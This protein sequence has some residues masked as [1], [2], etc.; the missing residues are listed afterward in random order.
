MEINTVITKVLNG[1]ILAVKSVIPFNYR[2]SKA[3]PH[4]EAFQTGI[5]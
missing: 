3:I 5:H 2:H 4:Q 1:S